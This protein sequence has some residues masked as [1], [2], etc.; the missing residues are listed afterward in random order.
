MADIFNKPD[1]NKILK[2]YLDEDDIYH[3]KDNMYTLDFWIANTIL[4][5]L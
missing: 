3:I 5:K 2:K 4:D 1:I